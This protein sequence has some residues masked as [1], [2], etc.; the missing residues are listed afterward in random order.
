MRKLFGLTIIVSLL[1][2]STLAFAG[3]KTLNIALFWLDENIDTT[4]GWNGWT[5]A[6]CGI[7]ENLAQIDEN[8]KM[9]PVI[10]ESWEQIDPTTTVFQIRKG[11]RFHNGQLVDAAACKASIERA[12][13]ITNRKDMKFPLAGISAD[14]YTLTIKTTKPYSILTNILADPV[15]II[16]DAKAAAKDPE[17]FKVKPVCTGPFKVASFAADKGLKLVKHEK[18]WKGDPG[19]D[20]VDVKYLADG[21]TRT[22]ALQSGEIDL[23]TQLNANDLK[24]FEGNDKFVVKKG[25][26]LRIFQLRLNFERPY[27]KN[28]KF[29]QAL[30]HGISKDVYATKLASGVPARGPFNSMLPFGYK[31]DDYYTYDPEKAKKLLDEAGFVDSDGDGIR[32]MKGKNIV[33]EY[34]F[35]TRHGKRAQTIGTAMQSQYKAIGLG[36][37]LVQLESIVELGKKGKFDFKF[38]RWTSAPTADP[39]YYLEASFKTGGYLN[40]GHYSNPEFDA[41][42]DK[43]GDSFDK[44][45]RYKLGVQ[46]TKMLMEDNAGIFLFYGLGHVV[47]NKNVDGIYRFVSEVYYIDDRVKMK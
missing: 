40:E 5:V 23:A 11:I 13:S 24:L 9:K 35:S 32:E 10:A 38:E 29:R 43:L 12:H 19:V 26:N 21:A 39:Q 33:M 6:R 8:L 31:G 41:L 25:P 28:P 44:A 2:A 27:M 46:G 15:Y 47:T 37:K 42:C 34:I 18:Y 3:G 4:T 7:G 16:V 45:E 22:M 17:G 1:L 36:L 20:T 14:G 30:M